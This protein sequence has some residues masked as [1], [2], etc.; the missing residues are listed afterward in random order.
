MKHIIALLL[1]MGTAQA[2]VYCC[3]E[4]A[5]AEY[6]AALASMS[7]VTPI[8]ESFEGDWPRFD[9]TSTLQFPEPAVSSKN[10][11]WFRNDAD[12]LLT[13]QI[14]GD[15]HDGSYGMYASNGTDHPVPDG[16]SLASSVNLYGIGGWHRGSGQFELGVFLDGIMVA[17]QV[18]PH[19][20]WAFFG[21]INADGFREVDFINVHNDIAYF[22]GDDYTIL[23]ADSVA[24]A[25]PQTANSEKQLVCEEE[26]NNWID[27]DCKEPGED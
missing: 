8:H 12:G 7:P 9:M 2:Q 16:Y 3:D 15:V 5:E 25:V 20:Q 27:G 10:L 1:F 22:W 6:L 19:N 11:V 18:L 23:Q 4:K 17:E 13:S 21:V 26:G 24:T 14:G